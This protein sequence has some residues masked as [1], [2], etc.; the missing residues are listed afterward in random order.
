VPT[1]DGCTYVET[2]STVIPGGGPFPDITIE[3]KRGYVAV[4]VIGIF[5]LRFFNTHLEGRN[6]DPAIPASSFF[7]AAQASELINIIGLLLPLEGAPVII[8]GDINS[9]P[10]DLQ[11]FQWEP[12]YMQLAAENYDVWTLRSGKPK[13]FTCCYDEDLSIPADLYERIDVIFSNELP[14]RVKANVMG[15][16]EADQTSSGLWP[17]DHAGVVVRMNFAPA[18]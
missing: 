6:P 3:F 10:E 8:V 15:N 13:G 9:S 4:D 17:S 16:D 18:P 1:D 11:T 7:Q 12:P 5:P 14:S 2:A